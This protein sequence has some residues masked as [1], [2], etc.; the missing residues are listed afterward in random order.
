MRWSFGIGRIAGIRVELHVTFLLFVAWVA[1]S[2]GITTGDPLRALSTALLLLLI[3][4]CVVLHELGH[5]LTARRFG[6]RTRDII[7][8]PIGGVARLERMPEKP[9]QEL[10]VAIAGPAVNVVIALAL[11][12]VLT[13]LRLPVQRIDLKGGILVS[14]LV[15][16]V[17]MVLFNLLPAFPMDGGRV[18][19]ALLAM[20]MSYARAT[21]VASIV[22]QG[23]ALVFGAAG[24]FSGNVMLMFIAMFVFLA[25]GE[26]RAIV[27]TR[28]SLSGLAVREAMLTE[29]QS[30][31]AGDPLQRAVDYL[32]AGSQHDFPVLER[33]VPVGMLSRGELVTAL[34]REGARVAVGTAMRRDE[35]SADAGEPLESVLVRMRERGRSA[36]P[37]LDRGRLVGLVTL[38]NIGDLLVVSKALKKHAR[39]S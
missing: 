20:R 11:L 37:V 10:L 2:Q 3:F 12:G 27:E 33:G 15:V 19:R 24:L 34:Q 30:L 9:R 6:I 32:I 23:A 5:A 4:T 7:L 8:L 16:N 35:E 28:A 21:R 26:E 38:E 39:A 29:F 36:L 17:A 14:L 13:L 25:A 18:L 31:D 1:V 22:G